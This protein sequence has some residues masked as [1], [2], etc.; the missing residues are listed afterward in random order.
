MISKNKTWCLLCGRHERRSPY[1]WCLE[2]IAGYKGQQ[3]E[4]IG[5]LVAQTEEERKQRR[6]RESNRRSALDAAK[7]AAKNIPPQ[8]LL[9][10]ERKHIARMLQEI[11]RRERQH[12]MRLWM[13][14]QGEHPGLRE[15]REPRPVKHTV[16]TALTDWHRRMR[17][18]MRGRG[19]HPG[20]RP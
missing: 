7:R 2:C 10:I 8:W 14:G 18:W 17:L 16:P 19:E 6:R 11:K 9:A 1:R 13:W 4:L 15:P 3:S 12:H 20:P 5:L